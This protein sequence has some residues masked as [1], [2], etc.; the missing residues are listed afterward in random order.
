[1]N[2]KRRLK[3]RGYV[4]LYDAIP[5]PMSECLLAMSKNEQNFWIHETWDGV[6]QDDYRVRA[7]AANNDAEILSEY[8]ERH[9]R[10]F[11]P[12][13]TSTQ[14]RFLKASSGAK[15]QPVRREFATTRDG[16][17]TANVC[18][19]SGSITIALQDRTYVYGYGWNIH[20]A[21]RSN[22]R[23]IELNKG[24]VL[25][26]RGDFAFSF[27]GS[28]STSVCIQG[29]VDTPLYHR[30]T[31]PEPEMVDLVDDMCDIDDLFCLYG[32]VRPGGVTTK[33][34]EST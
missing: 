29:H 2:A 3:T 25:L 10:T 17:V 24:D 28:T 12:L 32:T 13:A 11:F 7:F 23:I 5:D 27:A 33:C 21:M 31:F 9:Y 14:W 30:T 20:V 26:P 15:D 22:H 8:F 1:M 4:V 16:V 6:V 34:F 19:V 18:A